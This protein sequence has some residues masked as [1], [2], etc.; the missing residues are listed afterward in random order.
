[1][2]KLYSCP[3]YR[4]PIVAILEKLRGGLS[5]RTADDG[6]WGRKP[7][8]HHSLHRSITRSLVCNSVANTIIINRRSANQ[9]ASIH[10]QQIPNDNVYQSNRLDWNNPRRAFD[11]SIINWSATLTSSVAAIAKLLPWTIIVTLNMALTNKRT[12]SF[13]HRDHF[14][15]PFVPSSAFPCDLP[16]SSS[17]PSIQQPAVGQQLT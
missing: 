2:C 1:M 3:L 11:H 16:P 14:S 6:V 17:L 8:K 4:V 12:S 7:A 9:P 5:V 13:V 10:T 15:Y